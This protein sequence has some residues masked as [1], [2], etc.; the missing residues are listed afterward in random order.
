MDRYEQRRRALKKLASSLGYGGIA[1]IADAIGKVPN[2][3]SRMLYEQGRPGYKRIGEETWDAIVRA[4]P[5]VALEDDK[6]ERSTVPSIPA[7]DRAILDLYHGMTSEQRATWATVGRAL[8][9]PALKRKA[10]RG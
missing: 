10:R 7:D 8:A 3:V 5:A 1:A 9:Q 6:I 2:Y 4:F